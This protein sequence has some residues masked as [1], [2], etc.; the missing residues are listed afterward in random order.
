[1]KELLLRF[2]WSASWLDSSVCPEIRQRPPLV[3]AAGLSGLILPPPPSWL[4]G[5]IDNIGLNTAQNFSKN[6]S[7]LTRKARISI[8]EQVDPLSPAA[9]ER[10]DK[11]V[12]LRR[13]VFDH[14]AVGDEVNIEVGQK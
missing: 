11:H 13:D 9:N 5:S 4:C 12:L 8:R 7:Q 14:L 10:R 3:F 1:M 2:L 6:W